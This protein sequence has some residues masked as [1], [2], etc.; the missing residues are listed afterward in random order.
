[1]IVEDIRSF[2]RSFILT[3]ENINYENLPEEK[4]NLIA[5]F[6]IYKGKVYIEYILPFY[7]DGIY[8]INEKLLNKMK[9]NGAFKNN[10]K[11]LN[12]ILW[13][14]N[15]VNYRKNILNAILNYL[16][17]YQKKFIIGKSD[18]K[19]ISMRAIAK[20]LG[21]NVSVISRAVANKYVKMPNGENFK[22]KSFFRTKKD[23]TIEKISDILKKEGELTDKEIS[24][25]LYERC[26]IK[27]SVRT[28][29]YYRN[30]EKLYIKRK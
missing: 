29:N 24:K 25:L 11:E 6:E 30:M 20:E 28:V 19:P 21:V 9:K 10:E 23:F 12:E 13:N 2:V 4:F 16:V 22:I 18:L 7:S 14:I 1:M 8:C 17:D 27:L 5:A 15:K 26:N 3:H